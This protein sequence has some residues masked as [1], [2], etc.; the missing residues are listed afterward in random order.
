MIK[1]DTTIIS[2]A[3]QDQ[4]AKI[5]SIAIHLIFGRDTAVCRKPPE[6]PVQCREKP[7]ILGP[8]EDTNRSG[9]ANVKMSAGADLVNDQ[10]FPG[11][12]RLVN[13]S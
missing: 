2:P 13:K 7:Y 4:L 5:E 10:A 1:S 8:P 12:D 3:I 6:D 9:S 11:I